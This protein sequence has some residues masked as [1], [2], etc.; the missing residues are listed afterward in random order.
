MTDRSMDA[1]DE[2]R[3][4]F[5][6]VGAAVGAAAVSGVAK[7][8]PLQTSDIGKSPLKQ[9][10]LPW[11]E[12]ALEPVISA[13]TLEFHYGKHHAGYFNTLAGLVKDTPMA[14]QTL[15]EIIL[16]SAGDPAKKALF[17]NAAQ[18]WNHNFYWTSLT[19]DKTAPEGPLLNAIQRDFGSVD[20][21]KAELAKVTTA[22]FGSGWGWLVSEGGTLKVVSTSNAEVPFTNGQKP[23]L[24]VDV[25][26]HAYYLDWQNRR[27]DHVKAVVNDH[28]DWRFAAKNFA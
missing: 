15:E 3:R 21:L 10:P 13:R 19:P 5:L 11:A 7:A 4:N 17:N 16:A 24:T 25:W 20:A 2:Q 12:N 9:P 26:E 28:L 18:A 1:A 27:P 6:K 22:Q 14:D 23:L 8:A